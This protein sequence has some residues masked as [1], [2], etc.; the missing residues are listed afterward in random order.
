MDHTQSATSSPHHLTSLLT[1]SPPKPVSSTPNPIQP[2]GSID[3]STTS[4]ITPLTSSSIM[5]YVASPESASTSTT[6][7]SLDAQF[8]SKQPT[9]LS[10]L[11]SFS[12][13]VTANP[14]NRTNNEMSRAADIN[15]RLSLDKTQARAANFVPRTSRTNEAVRPMNFASQ[16][17][18]PPQS[19]YAGST[20]Y[21]EINGE[22]HQTPSTSHFSQNQHGHSLS[23][24]ARLAGRMRASTVSGRSPAIRPPP[25]IRRTSPSIRIS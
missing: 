2:V 23:T 7:P 14:I 9:N 1:N 3:L 12:S 25:S 19:A 21:Q 16:L 8:S 13:S 18:N 11:N 17:P 22:P 10:A 4:S 6:Y 24:L 5:N 20:F 15:L